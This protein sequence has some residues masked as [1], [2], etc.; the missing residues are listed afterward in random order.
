MR[1]A[2]SP[3]LPTANTSAQSLGVAMAESLV[4]LGDSLLS[5]HV[6]RDGDRSG[7]GL[8]WAHQRHPGGQG[9]FWAPGGMLWGE[10]GCRKDKGG[11]SRLGNLFS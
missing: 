1:A 11:R 3:A 10:G 8:L 4:V 9:W 5:Q 6:W 2:T 7:A